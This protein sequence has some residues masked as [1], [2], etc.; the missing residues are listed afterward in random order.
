M[1]D[2]YVGKIVI[3]AEHLEEFK[4]VIDELEKD[5]VHITFL[6]YKN[7]IVDLKE[8]LLNFLEEKNP[9]LLLI[10]NSDNNEG[11]LLYDFMKKQGYLRETPVVFIGVNNEEYKLQGLTLGALDYIYTPFSKVEVLTKVKNYITIRQIKGNSAVYD[12]LTGLYVKSYGEE[13][14]QNEFKIAMKTKRDF[15]ILAITFESIDKLSNSFGKVFRDNFLK[16]VGDIC[17]AYLEDRDFIYSHS[18]KSVVLVFENKNASKVFNVAEKIFEDIFKLLEE[19]NGDLNFAGGIT[20]LR[21][22]DNSF[23]ELLKRSFKAIKNGNLNEKGK[24]YIDEKSILNKLEKNILVLDDNTAILEILTN[25]Y[26]N[27]GYRVYTA[28]YLEEA[29]EIIEKE[30]IDLV[31]TDY[32]IPGI[33][34][35]EL[36]KTMKNIKK[37]L[38]IIVL[39]SQKNER[40]IEN[41]LSNG[42]DDYLAK[43]FSPIELDARLSRLLD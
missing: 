40:I 9:D 39:S 28:G 8:E 29:R 32:I 20:S 14:G 15:T 25:R 5:D 6:S 42:A 16:E 22:E 41:S 13:Y 1:E 7:S 27:K 2:N 31:I 24:I 33:T 38:K 17:R 3:C 4:D 19:D 12:D 35:I 43:P 34:G 37:G 10:D 21:M 23:K 26:R 30:D 36:I 18:E 11:I